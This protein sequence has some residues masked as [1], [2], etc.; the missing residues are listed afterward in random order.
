MALAYV[1]SGARRRAIPGAMLG[2]FP[3]VYRDVFADTTIKTV[4]FSLVATAFVFASILL[5]DVH[6]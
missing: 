3:G 4:Y 1:F 6:P 5:T 2:A